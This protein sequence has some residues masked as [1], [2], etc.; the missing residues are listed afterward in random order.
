MSRGPVDSGV[1]DRLYTLTGGRSSASAPRLDLLTRVVRE[2]GPVPGMPS[3]HVRILQLCGRPVAVA[4]LAGRV[5][6][7][8]GVVKIL[9]GDLIAAGRVTVRRP[10]PVPA[11]TAALPP[12]DTLKKVLR[13]L[14]NL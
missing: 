10:A 1:P 13:A 3:E 8:V 9:L 5:G 6:L 7:P 12:P 11:G 2:S 4:E 14:Q